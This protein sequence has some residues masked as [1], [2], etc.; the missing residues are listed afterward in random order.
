MLH[1]FQM[2]TILEDNNV[3]IPNLAEATQF[4]KI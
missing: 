4:D 2:T 1:T 3:K